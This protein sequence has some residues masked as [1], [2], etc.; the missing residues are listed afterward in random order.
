VIFENELSNAY[1]RPIIFRGT[2]SLAVLPPEHVTVEVAIAAVPWGTYLGEEGLRNGIDVCVSTWH[3]QSSATNPILSK[4]SGHYLNAQL[5]AGD[6]SRNGYSE[7]IVVNANGT[8]SEGSAE[9]I[10]LIREGRIYTPDLT[11]SILSGVTRDTVIHLAER[12]GF[13]VRQSSLPRDLLY[14]ADEIFLTG[15]AAEIT[16][17]RSVDRL[18]VG[19]GRPGPITRAIQDAFFGLFDSST[20]DEWGWLTPVTTS[21][22]MS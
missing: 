18:A 5:I 7:A 14:L 3:R 4:A 2:G 17:V 9:N 8:I 20:E 12:L 6:A 22:R 13:D 21:A 19:T 10:F 15:T 11:A 1:I 16:P